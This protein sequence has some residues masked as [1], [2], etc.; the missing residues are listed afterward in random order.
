MLRRYRLA[1]PEVVR[2]SR[3]LRKAHG[4]RMAA[5]SAPTRM[6]RPRFA[7][8]VSAKIGNAVLRH[9]IQ[10]R[11]REAMRPLLR[12]LGG[13]DIVVHVRSADLATAS[14]VGVCGELRDVLTRL[15]II[16]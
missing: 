5:A 10:R 1:D 16:R 15:G 11:L 8:V 12:G 14:W 7:I 9:R 4:R 3:M 6:G 13:V 2:R